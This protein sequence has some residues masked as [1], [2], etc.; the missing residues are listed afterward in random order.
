MKTK[1]FFVESDYVQTQF[2]AGL[3]AN[4]NEFGVIAG[5]NKRRATLHDVQPIIKSIAKIGYLV[6]RPITFVWS[7]D[8]RLIGYKTKAIEDVQFTCSNGLTAG[9]S[10]YGGDNPLK[11]FSAYIN[12]IDKMSVTYT[13]NNEPYRVILDGKRRFLAA[14][15]TADMGETVPFVEL[16]K[17]VDLE[18]YLE[19]INPSLLN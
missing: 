15:A 2:S 19:T 17:S 4:L 18:G 1:H 9:K 12:S 5:S 11:D 10:L 6:D 8:P 16:P 3:L 7:T 14:I 13:D